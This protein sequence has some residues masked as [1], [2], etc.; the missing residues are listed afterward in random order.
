MDRRR[1]RRLV[2]QAI[3]RLPG[4]FRERL[5]NIAIVVEDAPSDDQIR[6]AGLD[7][8]EDTLLGLFEGVPLAEHGHDASMAL[9]DRIVIFYQ[10]LIEVC[11]S[12]NEIREEIRLTL[13][14]EIAH[15]F[16]L[17]EDEIEDLGY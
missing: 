8:D 14:H 5:E 11:A 7:P 4:E 3:D 9:P 16:G 12:D 1:F 13:V 15:Y 2:G 17:D 6:S 10:P